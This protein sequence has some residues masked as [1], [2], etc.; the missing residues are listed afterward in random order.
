MG[1][2]WYEEDNSKRH[3]NYRLPLYLAIAFVLGMLLATYILISNKKIEKLTESRKVEEIFY[4]LDKYYADTVDY[5][6]L[7]EDAIFNMLQSL[8]PHSVYLSKDE[9]QLQIEAM[10][11][12]FEGIGIQFSVM[13]DTITVVATISGGPSERVGL[14]TGDKIVIV[15]G[16]NVAGINIKNE[17]ILKLLRGKKNSKVNVGIK[18]ENFDELYHFDI[19]RDIIPTY[20][21]DIA[22]MINQT[23]G[24]VKIN[25]FGSSTETEFR[26]ALLQ[27]KSKGMEKLILDLRG[28][29]GGFLEAG[30]AV[31]DEFLPKGELIVYTEGLKVGKDKIFAT[32]GGEF[33][34][35]KLVVLIDDFSASA[36]EIV[37]GAIQDNDRGTIVGRRSFG[38]G[39]IQRQINLSDNS[40]IRITVARYYTPSGRCIQKPFKSNI[41]DYQ[42]EV[43]N[44]YLHGEMESVDSIKFDNNLKCYTKKGREV[45]GGGGIMPDIFV[46]LDKDT[47]MYPFNLLINSGILSQFAFEYVAH[48]Q[49]ELKKKYR[50]PTDFIQ[51]FLVTEK[52]YQELIESYNSQKGKRLSKISPQAQ[53]EI[54][55][56][57]KGFIG[58]VLH[59]D[60]AFY[61]VINLSDKEIL[62]ALEL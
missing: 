2:R 40:S 50:T 4:Y 25:Q 15:D 53:K 37:A 48:N 49:V 30:V 58:R 17:E 5:T 23:T 8:D 11:G 60:E 32:R 41:Q 36:S 27:L 55:L 44:R 3:R 24:Y 46:P 59:Q 14:R 22:Y 7:F 18:R 26:K 35:G 61:P 51:Q 62:K 19:I 6:S 12:S 9:N 1:T 31:C 42:D 54:K 56:W 38:K 52:L 28:N 21:V 33:E 45:Y 47:S 16:K 57:L 20:T 43:W 29:P 39:L 10:E 13:R 34:T